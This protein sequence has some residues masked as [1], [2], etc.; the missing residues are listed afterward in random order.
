MEAAGIGALGLDWRALLFQVINFAILLLILRWVAYRPLLRVLESRRRTLEE[1]VH[2]AQQIKATH[3]RLAHEAATIRLN[4]EKAAQALLER[5]EEQA[6]AHR[7]QVEAEATQR[8]QR[9]LTQAHLTIEG[10]VTA[11][12]EALM[13][14]VTA[15][16]AL[17]TER[18][19]H[20]KLDDQR[21]HELIRQALEAVSRGEPKELL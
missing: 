6:Q 2:N 16:V 15:L 17:A 12:K 11:A 8:V 7:K 10:E 1:S 18:I 4:A 13:L 3:A 21:D 9:L 14:E 19:L 5:S 20:E